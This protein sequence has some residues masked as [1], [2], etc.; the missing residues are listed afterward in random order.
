MASLFHFFV[1]EYIGTPSCPG[2]PCQI[3]W[4][5]KQFAVLNVYSWFE[6]WSLLKR[7]KQH[8]DQRV[9]ESCV[10]RGGERRKPF[11]RKKKKGNRSELL[12]KHWAQPIQQFEMPCKRKKPLGCTNSQTSNRLH[13]EKQEQLMSQT[14]CIT[15]QHLKALRA[16][17][18]REMR[19]KHSGTK[20]NL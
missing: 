2:V 11:S 13:Q 1:T 18:Q 17:M 8:E 3:D 9:L 6:A 20:I 10:N 12:Y 7:R 14:S 4:L 19:H 16:E 15:W 5:F